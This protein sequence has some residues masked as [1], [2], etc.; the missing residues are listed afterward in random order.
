MNT[1]L[2]KIYRGSPGNQYFEEFELAYNTFT[3]VI[4]LLMEI[5]RNPV[6]KEGIKV[7]PI[8]WEMGCLEEVCGSCSMLVNGKPRQTCTAIIPEIIKEN[9]NNTII[10]APLS[11]FPLVRDLIVDRSSMFE[12]LKKAHAWIESDNTQSKQDNPFTIDQEKQEIMYTLSTCMTCGCCLEG[13]PQVNDKSP[14]EG[15]AVISQVR[16]F[17]AH[18]LGYSKK[19]QRLQLMMQE[20]GVMGCGNAQNCVKVCPKNIPLTESIALIFKETLQESI[21]N[22]FG[23]PDGS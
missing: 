16:L 21:K 17:N 15:A 12:S 10:L 13:C 14:F 11:K 4:S 23:A 2:L 5:Q 20:G 8:A 1:C 19:S 6:N 18:P 22:F 9:N 3:N 7:E